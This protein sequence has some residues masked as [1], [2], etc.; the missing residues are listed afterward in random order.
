MAYTG[1]LRRRATEETGAA[2]GCRLPGRA[3]ARVPALTGRGDSTAVPWCSP[4]MSVFLR[5]GS[6]PGRNHHGGISVCGRTGRPF[7]SWPRISCLGV[8]SRTRRSIWPSSK[9]ELDAS[10]VAVR[11]SRKGLAKRPGRLPVKTRRL[12]RSRDDWNVC[13]GDPPV[14][15]G[16][17]S[18]TAVRPPGRVRAIIEPEG[19]RIT[20][21]QGRGPL[22]PLPRPARC[23]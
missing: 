5:D 14:T 12:R 3:G 20:V 23:A 15:H 11:G 2:S 13:R 21:R 22:L 8:R 16:Q 6:Q 18:R 19:A 17:W 9:N 7:N 10:G 4:R 1:L